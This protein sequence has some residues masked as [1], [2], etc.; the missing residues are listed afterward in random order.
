MR[1][2]LFRPARQA[3]PAAAVPRLSVGAALVGCVGGAGTSTLCRALGP[4]ALDVGQR[5]PEFVGCPY[6]LVT[7][8]TAAGAAAAVGYARRVGELP[9]PV[10]VLVVA[11]GDGGPEPAAC[12]VRLRA[13]SGQVRAVLRVPHVSR[14]RYVDDPLTGPLPA[15]YAR[16]V[17]TLRVAVEAGAPLTPD[18]AAPGAPS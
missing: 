8:S 6:L 2:A 9:W 11:V 7:R 16:A 17:D 12:R 5:V 14:W 18:P 10:D 13:L 4:A 3:V 1:S 15:G